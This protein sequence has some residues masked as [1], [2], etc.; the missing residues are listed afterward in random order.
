MNQN[1]IQLAEKPIRWLLLIFAVIALLRG[2][3]FPGGG[4]IGGLLA[5]LSIVFKSFAYDVESARNSMVISPKNLIG[6][7]LSIVFI[8]LLPSLINQAEF[9]QAYWTKIEIFNDIVLKL[10]TP[11]IFDIGVFFVVIGIVIHFI[12]NL[13][14]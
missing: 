5:G 9:M 1:I 6:T 11:L 14:E 7:G 3:N 8:S 12:F 13:S 4:F 2:H 10:G